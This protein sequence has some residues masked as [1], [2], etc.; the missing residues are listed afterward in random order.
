MC[1]MEALVRRAWFALGSDRSYREPEITAV[2]R[3]HR[4]GRVRPHE[5]LRPIDRFSG[6]D[7]P[8]VASFDFARAT[9]LS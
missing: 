5:T 1:R 2:R 8:G 9:E 6:G 3:H 7:E 4:A